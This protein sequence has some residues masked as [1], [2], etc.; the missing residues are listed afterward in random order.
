LKALCLLL[1]AVAC[2]AAAQNT[3]NPTDP[4]GPRPGGG[5][6]KSDW[7]LQQDKLRGGES[8][9]L[10]ALPKDENLI[11]FWVTNSSAFRF[12][13]DAASLSVGNDHI[14]RYTLVA[15]SPSGVANVSYEGMHCAESKYAIYAYA[16]GGKWTARPTEW[17]PIEQRAVQ[18]WHDE[19][20]FRYF[21]VSKRG[22]L[23]IREEGL[24]ALRR[25]GHPGAAG[26]AG[27]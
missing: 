11:E 8:V 13:I 10:P 23:L 18:R 21:C 16:L 6:A 25:G 1:L 22:A 14:V 20:R 12:F 27:Y 9:A 4:T 17:K 2:Q 5:S 3:N 19:L 24:D 15:R 7:E 26:R